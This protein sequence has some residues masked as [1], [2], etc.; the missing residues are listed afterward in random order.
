MRIRVNGLQSPARIP[1]SPW[2][3]R[4]ASLWRSFAP[5]L[6]TSTSS[7]SIFGMPT[8]PVGH[9]RIPLAHR[10]ICRGVPVTS[11]GIRTNSESGMQD[12]TLSRSRRSASFWTSMK[13]RSSGE[14]TGTPLKTPCIFSWATTLFRIRTLMI[15]LPERSGR[16]ATAPSAGATLLL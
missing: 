5:S 13:I 10:T 8:V 6:P 15:S 1:L 12:S 14:M 2:R 9:R 7:W 11:T 4:R 16:M 3:F